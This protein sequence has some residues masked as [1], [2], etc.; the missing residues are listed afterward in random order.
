[1]LSKITKGR[2]FGAVLDYVFS[3]PKTKI[4]TQNLQGTTNNDRLSEFIED[5]QKRPR[6]KRPVFHASLSVEIGQRLNKTQWKK[7]IRAYLKEMGFANCQYVAVRHSDQPHDHVHIVANRVTRDGQLVSDSWDYLKSQAVVRRLEQ[8]FNHYGIKPVNSSHQVLESPC[9]IDEI[10]AQVDGYKFELQKLIKNTAHNSANFAEFKDKLGNQGVNISFN[11]NRKGIM[12]HFYG[13]RF[14]GSTLGKA[15]TEYGLKRYLINRSPQQLQQYQPPTWAI[16]PSR[17]LTHDQAKSLYKSYFR[18]SEKLSDVAKQAKL[19]GWNWEAIRFILTQSQRYKYLK[20][21]AGRRLALK[22]LNTVI[23]YGTQSRGI[24]PNIEYEIQY[25]HH[26]LKNLNIA[27]PLLLK[28]QNSV[29]T[30]NI[31]VGNQLV[32]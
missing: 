3:K 30:Q 28:T 10:E 17:W 24:S 23:A 2:D 21:K 12:Y 18:Q 19:D 4:L 9:T 6:V 29:K 16:A 11:Q 13:K 5:W 15:F 22:Y 1:M 8:K 14:V 7:V 20:E 27:V 25:T 32:L 31:S 26:H